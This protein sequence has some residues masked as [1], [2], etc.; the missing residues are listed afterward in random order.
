MSRRLLSAL[1]LMMAASLAAI[2]TPTETTALETCRVFGISDGDTIKV[3]CGDGEQE[4]VRL[5]EIDA[6]ESQQ[7]FGARAKQH[8]SDL[9]FGKDVQ[10]QVKETDRYGRLVA[11]VIVSGENINFR[12]VQDGYAWC[13]IQY[14]QDPSCPGRQEEAR[15]ARRGLWVDPNPTEPWKWRKERRS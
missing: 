6:P 13:Y 9:I 12:M 7:A 1:L 14:M 5:A 4:R 2:L 15:S 3:R 8:L 11:H 10:L